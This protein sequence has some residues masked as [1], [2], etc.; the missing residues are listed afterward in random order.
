MINVF[1]FE[2]KRL[3]GRLTTYIYFALMMLLEGY[4]IAN[5]N[6][7]GASPAIE[8]TAELLSLPL[9]ACLPLMTFPSSS[10]DSSTGFDSAVFTLGLSSTKLIFGKFIAVFTV[11]AV[12]TLPVAIMPFIL[13]AFAK[14]N[15][16]SAF[17]GITGY[18]LFGG[19]IISMGLFI[20]AATPKPIYSALFTYAAC[21]ISYS[22]E[23]LL[24]YSSNIT[25]IFFSLT[26]IS[27]L[28]SLAFM[29]ITHSDYAWLIPLSALEMFILILWFA[30]PEALK[31]LGEVIL[32]FIGIRSSVAG[33]CY[34]LL[35]LSSAINLIVF[36]GLML[37]LGIIALSSKKHLSAR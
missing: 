1:S 28:L 27:L 31:I 20:S 19:A 7:Y 26:A 16:L 11:F 33:F 3:L 22:C 10:K 23:W 5:I 2:L 9:L 29:K 37:S 14:I 35:D 4:F 25:V 34:G 21:I 36:C 15:L 30:F 12:S 18:L 24:L 6:L 8:Y 32:K 13:S 17:F